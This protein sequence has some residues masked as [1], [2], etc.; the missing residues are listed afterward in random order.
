MNNFFVIFVVGLATLQCTS[1][2]RCFS[3]ESDEEAN[4][5][6]TQTSDECPESANSNSGPA[7]CFATVMSKF[8]L[9]ISLVVYNHFF[10]GKSSGK[11]TLT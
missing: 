8:K 4:C 9:V 6:D 3:C 11:T 5:K 1:A 10:R 2:L 7:N